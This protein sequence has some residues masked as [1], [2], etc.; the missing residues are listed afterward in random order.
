MRSLPASRSASMATGGL[1]A[2]VL[3]SG[4]GG[5]T[6]AAPIVPEAAPPSVKVVAVGR[7]SVARTIELPA[8]VRA[9][10]Q[11]TLHAKVPG[12]VKSIAVDRGDRVRAEEILA[13]LEVPE[14]AADVAKAHAD[15][16]LAGTLAGRVGRA[17][18]KAPDLVVA[19][20]VDEATAKLEVARAALSRAETLLSFATIRAPF[21]GVVTERFV[22]VG[23]FVPAATGTA[24]AHTAAVVTVADF[25]KV[26]VAVGVPESETRFV[27]VGTAAEVKVD[28]A[29]TDAFV[30]TVARV[31]WALERNTRTMMAEIDI[32]NADLRLRPGML[33]HVRLGVEAHN[34]VLVVPAA[35]V[36]AEKAG[37]FVFVLGEGDRV[38]RTAI[39]PGFDDGSHVEILE[40]VEEGLRVVLVGKPPL[41]DGQVVQPTAAQ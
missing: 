12:F 28:E 22:D 5:D 16:T 17:H 29:G 11:V 23:S 35:A 31:A 9:W 40:G 37:S 41:R 7:G 1:L 27:Q 32:E 19:Q 6:G 33:A 18:S 26:R 38:R 34:G 13:E 8:E 39:K 2:A 24:T 20:N 21:D 10:Q 25:A 4:C 14:L 15:R 36:L 30:A 3:A